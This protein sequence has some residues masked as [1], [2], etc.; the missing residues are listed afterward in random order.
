[1]DDLQ[2]HALLLLVRSAS[3]VLTLAAPT[4]AAIP[5]STRLVVVSDIIEH[6]P[7]EQHVC[8]DI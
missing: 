8:E 7:H 4:I 6:D 3:S 1:M 2:A 5:L